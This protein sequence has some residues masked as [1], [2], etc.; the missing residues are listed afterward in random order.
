M[1]LLAALAAGTLASCSNRKNAVDYA[2]AY[3]GAKTMS[4]L[5]QEQ[6]DTLSVISP[7]QAD[8][9]TVS[10]ILGVQLGTM[11]KLQYN[12][13]SNLDELN[14]EEILAGLKDAMKLERTYTPEKWDEILKVSAGR[15]GEIMNGY[16]QKRMQLTNLKT[17]VE[18]ETFLKENLNKE[19]V[20]ETESGL[21]YKL[22]AEGEGEKVAPTDTVVVNYRGTLVDGTEF[23]ANEGISF[24]ANQVIKGWTEGLQ[25]LGKGGEAMLYIPSELAY[26]EYGTQSIPGNSALIFSVKVVDIKRGPAATEKA[27][28]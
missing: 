6:K 7:S 19:G 25:L 8:C 3:L 5:T 11:A 28:K 4:N 18:S 2:E 12:L 20:K 22:I 14:T 24:A 21:Q 27:T 16:I 26:G 17:Q 1:A 10:Y 23:D 9:D 13:A 15:V